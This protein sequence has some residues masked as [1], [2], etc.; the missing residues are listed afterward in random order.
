M[1]TPKPE[2]KRVESTWGYPLKIVGD[3][4]IAGRG[5]LGGKLIP[6]AIIDTSDRLDIEELIRI[7]HALIMPGDVKSQWGQLE[8]REE[9]VVLCL[10]FVRPSEAS[11]MIE[12]DI[13][14]QGS[15]VEQAIFGKAIYIQAGR[16][17][18]RLK[19]DLQRP[20]ILVELSDTG[21]SSVWNEIFAKQLQKKFQKNGLSRAASRHATTK[22]IEEL[23]ILS[24]CSRFVEVKDC[25]PAINVLCLLPQARTNAA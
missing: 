23:A 7:Q 24:I 5:V 21:F 16:N 22:V 14:R 19:T 1:K 3:A 2:I 17:G 4:G 11:L 9:T 12:F 8:K 6:L 15:L 18:D 10:T 13:A 20:K 25:C